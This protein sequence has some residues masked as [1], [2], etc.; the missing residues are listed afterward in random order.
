MIRSM[1]YVPASSERFVAKAHERGADAII[2]DLED[3]VAPSEKTKA[4]AS[5][6]LVGDRG[7]VGRWAAAHERP[8]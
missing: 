7:P 5:L 4:R 1:L 2:L 3:G 8:R 6:R